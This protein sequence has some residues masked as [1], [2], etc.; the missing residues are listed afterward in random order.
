VLIDDIVGITISLVSDEFVLHVPTEYDYR[1]A[2]PLGRQL[3]Q[4]IE[5]S[6]YIGAPPTKPLLLRFEVPY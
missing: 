5:N 3:S 6:Y 4:L 2:S 1:F